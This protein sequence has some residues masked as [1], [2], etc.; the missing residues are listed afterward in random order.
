MTAIEFKGLT[1]APLG[2]LK[3]IR[4][5]MELPQMPNRVRQQK[6]ITHVT[7]DGNG[8]LVQLEGL[9]VA[10]EFSP[11]IAEFPERLNRLSAFAA[12]F[13]GVLLPGPQ[14]RHMAS[15]VS[16]GTPAELPHSVHD[17]S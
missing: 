11:G 17:P 8:F 13:H 2:I 3:T 7:A 16:I 6:G 14:W 4:V 10:P 1:V 9:V 5:V 12:L 15:S